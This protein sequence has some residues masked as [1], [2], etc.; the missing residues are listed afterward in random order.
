SLYFHFDN[1]KDSDGD[2]RTEKKGFEALSDGRDVYA[3][4]RK[5]L[6]EMEGE[7]P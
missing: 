5:R 7:T 4:L 1:Y 6:G 2:R 3:I